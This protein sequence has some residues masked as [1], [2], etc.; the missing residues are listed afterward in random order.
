MGCIPIHV[1]ADAEKNRAPVC[2]FLCSR[3][4][5]KRLNAEGREPEAFCSSAVLLV[6]AVLECCAADIAD[7]TSGKAGGWLEFKD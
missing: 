3:I 4:L 2:T 6:M 1:F 5:P 7:Q